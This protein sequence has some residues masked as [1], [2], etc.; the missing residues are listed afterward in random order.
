MFVWLQNGLGQ[1]ANSNDREKVLQHLEEVFGSSGKQ[2]AA[3]QSIQAMGTNAIPYLIETLSYKQTQADKL[4]D[5]AY[6]KAPKVVQQTM[7]KPAALE[8]L[9]EAAGLLLLNMPE[10]KLYLGDLIP[11]LE[12]QQVT[13]RR[14]TA[15]LLAHHARTADPS[16]ILACLPALKNSDPIVRQNMANAF[17]YDAAKLPRVKLALEAA[18]NDPVENVRLAVAYSLLKAD[19]N[20]P[21]ALKTLEALFTSTDAGTRYIA[22]AYYMQSGQK[23]SRVEDKLL[24]IFISTISGTPT[25]LRAPA[26]YALSRFGERAKAAVPVL[27]KHLQS[28]DPELQKAAREAL[29][30]IAPEAMP[31]KP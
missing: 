25:D 13:V 28:T 2:A 7:S 4:Y 23:D 17:I 14:R 16:T 19:E 6:A 15:S 5:K 21:T 10:T 31:M 8:T 12:D 24:P 18:L 22:A 30:K 26:C 3:I 9:R 20:H 29:E 27:L 1:T 11:L